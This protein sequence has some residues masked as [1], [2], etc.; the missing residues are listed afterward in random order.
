MSDLP[1]GID[2]AIITISAQ[3]AVIATKDC[4]E[5]EIP[6]IIIIAGGFGE[7]G[8][9]GKELEQRLKNIAQNSTSRI[10][11][12]NSLGIFFPKEKID[13]IFVEH[14]D[15]ALSGGGG[16]ACIA[17]SGSV[18]VEALGYASNIGF[19]M[20]AFVGLGNKCDLN[21]IDFLKYFENDPDTTCI[22]FYLENFFNGKLF[23]KEAKRVSQKKPV[24][25]LKAGRSET[26]VSAAASHTGKLA[27][28]DI[29]VKGTFRQFGIQ[30]V[31]DDQ[32]LT[33]AARTLSNLPITGGNRVAVLTPAGGYGVMC[34]DYIE[35][36][37]DRAHLKMAILSEDTKKRI[38]N[39]T[40]AFASCSNPVDITASANDQMFASA[41][42]ALIDDS[43]VDI[44]ICI[45]FFSPPGITDNLKKLVAGRV[46]VS[47]KPILVFTNYGPY[48]DGFLK[49]FYLDG[50]VG[51][52]SVYRTVTAARFLVER[53]GII[54]GALSS[55][56]NRM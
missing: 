14:G 12:P 23:L 53:A 8:I 40:F 45:T 51:F 32:E 21:E 2:L 13:T 9:E 11:G 1:E 39:D 54:K 15:K 52:P 46:R 31:Y 16:V 18:G 7:T 29:T 3:Y 22:A 28:A 47:G 27:G 49:R 38:K 34:T 55:K 44:I 25:V 43:G 42:D 17:Q 48:T 56:K 20:R 41:L 36:T 50:V 35:E 26:A 37:N 33:D 24:L 5:K 4:A 10:L 30:R 19:G 6:F